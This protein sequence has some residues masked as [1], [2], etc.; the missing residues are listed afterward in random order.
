ME[1]ILEKPQ[2]DLPLKQLDQTSL[3]LLPCGIQH[4]GKANIPGFFFLVDGEYT[5]T[6]ALSKSGDSPSSIVV[7]ALEVAKES[8]TSATAEPTTIAT[9]TTTTTTTT[10]SSTTASLGGTSIESKPSSAPETSFRGR[11]LKGTVVSVPEGYV[12]SI[13]RP[14]N[15]PVSQ[16]SSNSSNSKSSAM[17]MDED[18]EYE[19]MLRGMQE[20]RKTMKAQAQFKEFMIWGHDE[21]P[22]LTTDKVIR[23]MQWI[24][25]AKVL[26]EPLC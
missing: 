13:Y 19:A 2:L 12:G 24:D 9:T 8:T 14:V 26:H 6:A 23:A 1:T 22:S 17:D 11:T 10:V 18:D 15:P 16:Q 20:E 25:I 3:H 21:Q 5:S 4:D 7:E